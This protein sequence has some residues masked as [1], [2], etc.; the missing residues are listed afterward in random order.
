MKIFLTGATGWVGSAILDDL[1]A[2][3]HRV[4]GLV[5]SEEK[6][7]ALIGKG[8]EPVI[9]TLDDAHIL[10]AAASDA[11]AVVH[12]AFHHDFSRFA[13]SAAQDAR[14][15]EWMGAALVGTDTPLLVTNGLSGL[16]RGANEN[17]RPDPASP[18]R[19]EA[20]ARVVRERGVRVATVRLACSVHGAG[21]HAFVPALIALAKRTGVSAWI[22]DGANCWSGVH[23]LD[24]ARVYRLALEAGLPATV[25]HAI[26]DPAVPFRDIARKIADRLGVPAEARPAEHFGGFAR[27]AGADLAASSALTRAALDWAPVGPS[28]MRDL[29]EPGYYV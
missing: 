18:R 5:R 3:G 29:D 6:A 12:T 10:A 16:P 20:A 24:A 11:D 4:A 21:D 2:H 22:G 23:R 26:A 13:E 14:A 1:L 19:S 8:A 17:D 25:Y 9:G 15:I 27:M 7:H 28:L